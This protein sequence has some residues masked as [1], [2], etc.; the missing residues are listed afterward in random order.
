M[1]TR[2]EAEDFLTENLEG[3]E[4]ALRAGDER[5]ARINREGYFKGIAEYAELLPESTRARLYQRQIKIIR[6]NGN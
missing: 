4:R 5:G 2:T 1:D 3:L 6:E